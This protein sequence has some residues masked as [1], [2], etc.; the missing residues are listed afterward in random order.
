MTKPDL[1]KPL[2]LAH[3]QSLAKVLQEFLAPHHKRLLFLVS[4]WAAALSLVEMLVAVAV[5]PY[6]Q[7]VGGKCPAA[8]VKMLDGWPITLALSGFL[9]LL[10]TLKFVAQ[11]LLTWTTSNFHQKVQRDTVSRLLRGYLHLD[12]AS[13]QSQHRAHYLRRCFTT[14]IDA[15]YVSQQ[16]VALISSTLMLL[17]LTAVLLWHDALVAFGLCVCMLILG[18]GSQQLIGRAQ[19]KF[20]HEREL[21]TQRWNIGLAE[22]LGSF[23]EIRIYGLERFFLDQ[24]DRALDS[25]AYSN[26][27]LSFMPNLPRMVLEFGLFSVLLTLISAWV[28][29]E[30][31]IADLLPQIIFYAFVVRA[32]MPAMINLLSTGAVLAGSIV[33][34]ELVLQEFT[35]A[36]AR[37]TKHIGIGAVATTQSFFALKNVTFHHLSDQRPVVEN[38]NLRMNH[39]SWLALTGPSGVGKSTVMELLCGINTPQSGSVIHAWSE[40]RPPRVAYLPQQ[41][42][43]LDGTIADNVVFGFDAGDPA[44]IDQALELSCLKQMVSMLPLGHSARVGTDGTQLSGGERQRLA[45]ARALYRHPDLLLLDEATSGLDE[46]TETQVLSAVKHARPNMSVVFVTHRHACL[47]F[48]DQVISLGIDRCGSSAVQ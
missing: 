18:I 6:V 39:P 14:A 46:A 31:P 40:D 47:R 17:F 32:L 25:V 15:S 37:D 34:M 10:I 22:C 7:C 36:A 21:A 11:G 35:W 3:A 27:R 5:V 28:F 26:R 30:R 42:A 38:I 16:A 20:A 43:L 44:K 41:V 8:V 33:N 24:L 13:F 4:L 19:N 9:F 1:T 29:L 12:W 48:A 45:L 2:F 23:R